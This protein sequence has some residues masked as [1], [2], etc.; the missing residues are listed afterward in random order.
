MLQQPRSHGVGDAEDEGKDQN[1][2][3]GEAGFGE[4]RDDDLADGVGV[5]EAGE[6]DKRDEVVEENDGLEIQVYGNERPGCEE[7]EEAEESDASA[8]AAGAAGVED[9]EGAVHSSL[10]EERSVEGI[11]KGWVPLDGVEDEYDAAVHHIPL[12]PRQRVESLGNEGV[13]LHAEVFEHRAL[14]ETS[15]ADVGCEGIDGTERQDTF[16][17][18][19]NDTQRER[20]RVVLVPGLDVECEER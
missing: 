15:P 18:A 6:E 13:V 8:L 9:V 5:Y 10:E 16:D 1:V 3:E 14:P 7:G 19:G 12:V 4:V 2:C 17:R 11:G 20:G